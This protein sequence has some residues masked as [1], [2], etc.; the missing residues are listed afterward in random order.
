MNKYIKIGDRCEFYTN[1]AWVKGKV[2][3]LLPLEMT[4]KKGIVHFI[5]EENINYKHFK[6]IP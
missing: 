3:N 5:D 6:I 2:T 4:D 1:A